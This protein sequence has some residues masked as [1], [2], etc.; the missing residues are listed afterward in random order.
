MDQSKVVEKR[1]AVLQ[2]WSAAKEV[3]IFLSFFLNG[4][5]EERNIAKKNPR[6]A[7]FEHRMHAKDIHFD[8]FP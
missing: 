7:L 3:V 8:L 2:Q 5:N 4:R 6:H 1:D